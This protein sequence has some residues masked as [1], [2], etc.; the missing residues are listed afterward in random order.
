M[1]FDDALSARFFADRYRD[2]GSEG[3]A[4]CSTF[5]ISDDSGR[6]HFWSGDGPAYRWEDGPLKPHQVAFFADA[7]AAHSLLSSIPGGVTL[8]AAGLRRGSDAF[9]ITGLSTAGKSTTALA[10]VVAGAQLYS[11]ERCLTTPDGAVPF[12]RA[13]NL[14]KGGIDLLLDALPDC[15]LRRRLLLRRGHDW[16]SARFGD[17]FGPVQLPEPAPL[18]ALF[19]IVGHAAAPSSRPISAVAML[20]LAERGASVAARGIDRVRALL[21][22]LQRVACFELVLG[23]PMDSAQHILQRVDEVIAR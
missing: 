5:A 18:R 3:P 19:A 14:R 22:L 16:E 4:Q 12:P 11:D 1:H 2:L 7:F 17:V 6:L 15:E 10:C 13:L 8:H 20:P 9:A 21:E 23:T